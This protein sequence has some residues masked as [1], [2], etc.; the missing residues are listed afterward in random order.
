[1]STTRAQTAVVQDRRPRKKNTQK[2]QN[3]RQNRRF[4]REVILRLPPQGGTNFPQKTIDFCPD[5]HSLE[6]E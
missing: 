6:L 5:S 1:M 2:R 4:L 3:P